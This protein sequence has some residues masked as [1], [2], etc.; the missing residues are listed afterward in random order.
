NLQTG[1]LLHTLSGHTD[2]VLTVAINDA[3]TAIASGS[4]DQTIKI[5]DLQTGTERQTFTGHS[6]WVLSVTFGLDG[7]T[8]LSG[9]KDRT[10]RQ[11]MTGT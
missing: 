3:G 6:G 8:V 4:T 10:V 11:W 9:S 1:Q 2:R 7:K 5:W